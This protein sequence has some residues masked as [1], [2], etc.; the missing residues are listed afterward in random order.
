MAY[1]T[2]SWRAGA[3]IAIVALAFLAVS[4]ALCAQQLSGNIYG[5]V[6]DE[7]GGRLPGVTVTLTGGGAPQT[8]KTD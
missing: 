2:G 1:R 4:G 5:S 6:T 8:N 7:Q 3:A